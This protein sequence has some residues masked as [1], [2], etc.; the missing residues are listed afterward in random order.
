MYS[1]VIAQKHSLRHG[2]TR[3]PV[4][5]PQA[6]NMLKLEFITAKPNGST[7]AIQFHSLP[8]LV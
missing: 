4:Q 7:D 1:E 5:I 6:F 3:R 8:L 2:F